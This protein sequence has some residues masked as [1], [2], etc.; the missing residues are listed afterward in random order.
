MSSIEEK[1][2]AAVRAS[3]ALQLPTLSERFARAQGVAIGVLKAEPE[4]ALRKLFRSM[5]VTVGDTHISALPIEEAIQ[6]YVAT[7]ITDGW[8]W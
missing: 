7:N 6:T 4:A 8:G 5:A 2:V 1:I 3:D